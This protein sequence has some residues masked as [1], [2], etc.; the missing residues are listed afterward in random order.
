[1]K[2]PALSSLIIGALAVA[3]FVGGFTVGGINPAQAQTSCNLGSDD[4]CTKWSVAKWLTPTAGSENWVRGSV[5]P[6]D[7]TVLGRVKTDNGE[8]GYTETWKMTGFSYA[9]KPNA[10][11]GPVTHVTLRRDGGDNFTTT[12]GDGSIQANATTTYVKT[13]YETPDTKNNT[14]RWNP[15]SFGQLRWAGDGNAGRSQIVSYYPT[16]WTISGKFQ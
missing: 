1:M 4:W 13:G 3:A 14:E 8:R 6:S 11:D 5:G 12:S 16:E 15:L 2:K 10:K 7:W 9:Y